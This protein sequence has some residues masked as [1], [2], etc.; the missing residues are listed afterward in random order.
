[1]SLI[2]GAVKIQW[3]SLRGKIQTEGTFSSTSPRCLLTLIDPASR[4]LTVQDS[5]TSEDNRGPGLFH[6]YLNPNVTKSRPYQ[7]EVTRI[8][9]AVLKTVQYEA[10]GVTEVDF[11]LHL[12]TLQPSWGKMI[13]MKQWESVTGQKVIQ[14]CVVRHRPA[15]WTGPKGGQNFLICVALDS[16]PKLGN[17]PSIFLGSIS[18][19]F[20]SPLLS[21]SQLP[22]LSLLS[23]RGLTE[24]FGA[25][26]PR[27]PHV[28]QCVELFLFSSKWATQA[29]NTVRCKKGEVSMDWSHQGGFLEEGETAFEGRGREVSL[30]RD[31]PAGASLWSQVEF[32]PWIKGNLLFSLS[33]GRFYCQLLSAAPVLSHWWGWNGSCQGPDEASG[34]IQAGPR[35]NFQRGTSR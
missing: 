35:Y 2:R 28:N 15:Y 24:C 34:H 16:L 23:L 27:L 4:L 14:R 17:T 25:K 11:V 22:S 7:P 12:E 3:I 10:L 13:N 32:C 26:T 30:A 1:M 20:F 18:T 21:P 9:Q 19:S 6:L 31:P 8:R 33:F 5:L 29:V